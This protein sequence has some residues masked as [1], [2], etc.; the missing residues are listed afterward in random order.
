M[1]TIVTRT[2]K[3]SALTWLE[4]DA[5]FTNLNNDKIEVALRGAV[6]GIAELGPDQKL[7]ASQMPSTGINVEVLHPFLLMGA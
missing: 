7:K 6:N 1:A 2:G 3:G 4:H 5:N